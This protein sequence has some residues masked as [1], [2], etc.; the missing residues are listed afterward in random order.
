M[1]GGRPIEPTQYQPLGD[2]RRF[3]PPCD[4]RRAETL[5]DESPHHR[6]KGGTVRH[7]QVTHIVRNAP[8]VRHTAIEAGGD[9]LDCLCDRR[10]SMWRRTPQTDSS[11]RAS[12]RSLAFSRP[13]PLL[14]PAGQVLG[15]AGRRA[16]VPRPMRRARW[17]KTT[18]CN[19]AWTQKH[20]SARC[21][22]RRARASRSWSRCLH[23]TAKRASCSTSMIV[24][25]RVPGMRCSHSRSAACRLLSVRRVPMAIT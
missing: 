19:L 25:A 22:S 5:A 1:I 15:A 9:C 18:T 24:R 17:P 6:H 4:V 16:A 3:P 11:R 10:R 14:L 21:T 2:R 7:H 12:G 8:C 20:A 13:W 23:S